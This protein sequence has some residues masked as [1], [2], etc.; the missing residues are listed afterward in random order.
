MQTHRPEASEARPARL[1]VTRLPANVQ[2]SFRELA[3]LIQTLAPEALL[4]LTPFGGW[5]ADDPLYADTPARSVAVMSAFD[6]RVLDQLGREG[7]QFGKRGLAAPLV[8]TPEYIAAVCDVFPLEL[9]EIRE[10]HET[11]LGEDPFA[12]LRFERRDV[13]LQCERELRSELIQLR[14][15]LVAVAGK[16]KELTPLCRNAAERTARVLRG[17]L[18][19]ADKPLPRLAAELAEATELV[20]GV[21]LPALR[22][23]TT[24]ASAVDFGRFE[25]FYHEL[26]SLAAYVNRLTV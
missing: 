14:H 20:A 18:L 10:L 26:T 6:L 22:Q 11:V 9:L 24:T 12:S 4:S 17:V 21:A 5:L 19:L 2:D 7:V 3:Q 23:V 1:D 13:R 15:G 25:A 8:M 16:H